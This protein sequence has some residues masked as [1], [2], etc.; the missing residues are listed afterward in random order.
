[1]CKVAVNYWLPVPVKGLQ[2]TIWFGRNRRNHFIQPLLLFLIT[3]IRVGLEIVC[4]V[5]DI[6][7]NKAFSTE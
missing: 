6:P 7:D 5:W 3:R 2:S 1:M 4:W